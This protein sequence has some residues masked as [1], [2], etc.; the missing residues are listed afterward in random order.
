MNSQT[1]KLTKTTTPTFTKEHRK[2]ITTI[3]LSL[4]C[5][6]GSLFIA[7]KRPQIDYLQNQD[8]NIRVILGDA[9]MDESD[10]FSA[11]LRYYGSVTQMTKIEDVSDKE[12]DFDEYGFTFK[13][14]KD[15]PEFMELLQEI[16]AA[17]DTAFAQKVKDLTPKI[18]QKLEEMLR[19]WRGEL[20]TTSS[21]MRIVCRDNFSDGMRPGCELPHPFVHIDYGEHS[22]RCK[23]ICSH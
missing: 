20:G 9:A 4:F 16:Q 6:F 13:S 2:M 7:M 8:A 23:N 17:D 11:N 18:T 21:T 15:S 12:I 5:T 22:Y 3:M 14:F 1:T 19:R 10:D